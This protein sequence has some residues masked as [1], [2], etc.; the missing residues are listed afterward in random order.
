MFALVVVAGVVLWAASAVTTSASWP[1][2]P[3]SSPTKRPRT[4]HRAAPFRRQ[5]RRR[6]EAC[7][8]PQTTCLARF[9]RLADAGVGGEALAHRL[10]VSR[11]AISKHVSALREAGYVI[12]AAPS[13]GY[14]LLSAPDLPLPGEV[15]PLLRSDCGPRF[16]EVPRPARPTTTPA[17][18]HA[19]ARRKAAWCWRRAR[20]AGRGRLGRAWTSPEGGVYLSAV[21]R[22]AVAPVEV[23]SLALAVALGVVRGSSRW[24]SSPCS[25]GPTTCCSAVESSPACCW[26]CR[27]SPMRWSG[28]SPAW[29]STCARR[30][31]RRA[32]RRPS[33]VSWAAY[34]ADAVRGT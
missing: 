34:L 12:D 9:A 5:R 8:H 17:R 18:S 16:P 21:L 29:A 24:G 11:V 25:S 33:R 22:P 6:R 10:G 4:R 31:R 3:P 30:P 7:E 32:L 19:A 1:R 23:A 2:T 20:R 27:R 26:R 15:G 14:R 28:S 13:S